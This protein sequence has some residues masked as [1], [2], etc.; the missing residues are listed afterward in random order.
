VKLADFGLMKVFQDEEGEFELRTKL[1]T[2]GYMAPE[3]R[4]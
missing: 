1:G 3:I 2:D 4:A